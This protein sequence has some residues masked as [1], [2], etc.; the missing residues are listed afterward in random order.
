VNRTEL[1]RL[2][3]PRALVALAALLVPLYL[4]PPATAAAAPAAPSAVTAE[5]TLTLDQAVARALEKN[6]DIV[7]ER[8]SLDSAQAAVT[9]AQGAYDPL[10]QVSAGWE[11]AANPVNS[12]FSGAPAGQLAPTN[13]TADASG[14]L[15]QL[16]PSGATVTLRAAGSRATTDG[17][18]GLLSPAW[19]T[20]VGVE[21][22]QP[23]LRDRAI[24]PARLNLRVVAADRDLAAASLRRTVTETVAAV[25]EGYW[26]LAASSRELAV[27]EE[28]IG[29][30][31]HQLDDTRVRIEHG[32][33]PETELAQP[34]AELERRRGELLMAQEAQA[35]AENALKLLILGD[36][37]GD[38]WSRHLAP[39][40]DSAVT[41][42]PVDLPA[43]MTAALDARPELAEAKAAIARRQAETAFA[44]D[45]VRPALD[46]V[47]SY[48]RFGL[49]GAVNPAA[50]SI[51]G[52]P[53]DVPSRLDGGLG[54]SFSTLGSGDFDDLRLGLELTVPLR[55]RAARANATIARNGE[56]QAELDLARARKQVRAEVLDAGA[57][58]DTAG[59]RIETARAAR[60]AAEVQL[61][62]EQ[63]RFAAGLS[64]NF[65][66]LTRQNDLSSARLDEISASTDYRAARTE[67]ARATG[68]LLADRGIE[69]QQ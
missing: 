48:D 56:R 35:R 40:E 67:M 7:V 41:V 49:A 54:Q 12:A 31:Q 24:D 6:E 20:Q 15:Q 13:D 2:Y 52:L 34:K 38:L 42:T 60:E 29:L 66:V 27:R 50:S 46:A 21:L 16:L 63:D 58:L 43:A 11:R 33:S 69:L 68:S 26:T 57:A 64:T 51:P 14:S 47:V 23:L 9:G 5:L 36:D 28:A 32:V 25:E 19:G 37:D 4:A 59:Q 3:P 55:N 61:S 45:A 22:R 44:R 1:I 65:L 10:L 8:T 17:T 39:V 18:F 62:A 30:A 53:T